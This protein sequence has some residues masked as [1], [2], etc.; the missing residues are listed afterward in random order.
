M[1]CKFPE[2][3]AV[4]SHMLIPASFLGPQHDGAPHQSPHLPSI[5]T[6][7]SQGCCTALGIRVPFIIIPQIPFTFLFTGSHFLEYTLSY[8]CFTLSFF[9]KHVLP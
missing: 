6:V 5:F 8:F 1:A 9:M 7:S 4:G 2:Y 3:L